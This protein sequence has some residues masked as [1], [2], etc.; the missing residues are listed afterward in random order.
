MSATLGDLAGTFKTVEDT[1]ILERISFNRSDPINQNHG[2]HMV[3]IFHIANQSVMDKYTGDLAGAM[4]SAG[5]LLI[6]C[7]HNGS[8]QV[9]G[10]GL[11][12][13]AQQFRSHSVTLDAL[14]QF[15][16]RLFVEES[17]PI[18]INGQETS[19]EVLKALLEGLMGWRRAD[20]RQTPSTT[21]LDVGYL[22]ELG[23]IYMQAKQRGGNRIDI[24]ADAAVSA[25]PLNNVPYRVLS[26]KLAIK[27]WLQALS[28]LQSRSE[29]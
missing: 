20:N 18:G 27:T 13:L 22:F 29:K 24:L 1:L 7:P 10:Q 8:A 16:Q 9:Y 6:A 19:S 21:I 17:G 4:E 14:I 23:M 3:E 15:T 25:S 26:G 11:S 5:Q 2:D 28:S 12:Q